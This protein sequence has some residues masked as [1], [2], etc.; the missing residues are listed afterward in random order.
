MIYPASSSNGKILYIAT[1][2]TFGTSPSYIPTT[3]SYCS[4]PGDYCDTVGVNAT[5][6]LYFGANG[7]S[8]SGTAQSTP[9]Q[10]DLAMGP[11]LMF[12]KQCDPGVETCSA[13]QHPRDEKPR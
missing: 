10:T 2:T 12:G 8:G 9:A 7:V 6:I 4:G 13:T 3:T 5:K 1:S 11:I